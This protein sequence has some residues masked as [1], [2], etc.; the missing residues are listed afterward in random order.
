M[1]D[2]VS[3]ESGRLGTQKTGTFD[4]AKGSLESGFGAWDT[5]GKVLYVAHLFWLLKEAFWVL[6]IPPVAIACGAVSVLLAVEVAWRRRDGGASGKLYHEAG[7]EVLIGMTQ[8]CWLIFNFILMITSFIYETPDNVPGY[9]ESLV[10][11]ME[12]EDCEQSATYKLLM[13]IIRGGFI[14]AFAMWVGSCTHLFKKWMDPP[15]FVAQGFAFQTCLL[16]G[17]WIAFWVLKDF[18]WTFDDQGFPIAVAAWAVHFVVL[19]FAMVTNSSGTTLWDG[20]DDEEASRIRDVLLCG[21]AVDLI[22]SSYIFWSISSLLWLLMEEAFDEDLTLRSICGISCF[23]SV[24]LFLKGY[25]QAKHKAEALS[26]LYQQFSKLPPED[27]AA[28]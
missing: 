7:S 4:E 1:P 28:S 14:L 12:C 15:R 8:L 23:V 6:L 27:Q 13:W 2:K 9:A 3:P 5:E 24:G 11:L 17:G 25:S 22:H 21:K 19:F 26:V 10:E 16:E 20:I 18:F